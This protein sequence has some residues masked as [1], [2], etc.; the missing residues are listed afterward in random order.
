M[1]D[2]M[3]GLLVRLQDSLF[4]HFMLNDYVMSF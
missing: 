4:M 1:T 2:V 3:S